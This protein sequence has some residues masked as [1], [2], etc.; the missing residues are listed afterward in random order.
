MTK[1][2]FRLPEDPPLGFYVMVALAL[3]VYFFLPFPERT[4]P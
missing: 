1:R 3:F 2:W 4:H